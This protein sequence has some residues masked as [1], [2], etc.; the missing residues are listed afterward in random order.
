VVFPTGI[1]STLI[2]NAAS[3]TIKGIEAEFDAA[4]TS[5]L[6]LDGFFTYT[7]AGYDEFIVRNANTGAIIQDRTKEPFEL[8]KY[9]A[10]LGVKYTWDL[11]MGQ[12]SARVDWNWRSAT[13]LSA[14][15]IVLPTE[16]RLYQGAYSLFGARVEWVSPDQ[17]IRAAIVGRNLTDKYFLISG[18]EIRAQG[19]DFVSPGPPRYI[20][21]ELTKSFGG[22]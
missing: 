6:R 17:S 7:D 20:G 3:A 9:T 19:F 13:V 14:A 10:A 22:G 21:I 8:P 16:R 4:P 12:V 11:P 15:S 18:Q 5:A 2:R 1:S